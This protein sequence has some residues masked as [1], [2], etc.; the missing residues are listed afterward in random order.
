[1]FFSFNRYFYFS[2][3]LIDLVPTLLIDSSLL[4][5]DTVLHKDHTW[6]LLKNGVESK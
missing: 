5:A 1:M 3:K 6:I 2:I 4:D